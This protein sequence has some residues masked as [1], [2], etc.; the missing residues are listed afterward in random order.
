MVISIISYRS[1]KNGAYRFARAIVTAGLIYAGT[2]HAA[3]NDNFT[4]R[5][6]EVLT[7]D[8]GLFLIATATMPTGPCS[9]YW[10][11]PGDVPADARQ[12]LLSRALVA[13]EKGEAINIG[14]DHETCANG[15]Y[16]VHRLG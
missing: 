9:S 14:Y 8:S 4:T 6:T 10:M 12:M 15:W 3:Y 11:V 13:R 2:S 7:Y 1:V 5:I 16:R